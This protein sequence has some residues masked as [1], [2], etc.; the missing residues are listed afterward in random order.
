MFAYPTL[1]V[2]AALGFNF[3]IN[4]AKNKKM[5]IAFTVLPVVLLFDPFIFTVRN[6]PYEATYCN[7]F[8]GGVKGAYGN[9]DLY[10]LDG[11][12]R[13]AAEWI[14]ADVAKNGAPD[15]T[16]KTLVATWHQSDYYFRKDTA[17]FSINYVRWEERNSVD[18]D[19][20]FYAIAGV[21]HLRRSKEAYPPQNT[22]YQVK[23]DG[24]PIALVLKREDR[25]SYYGDIAFLQ[26]DYAKA[27]TQLLKALEYDAYDEQ[28]LNDFIQIYLAAGKPEDIDIAMELAEHWQ[29]FAKNDLNA[30]TFMGRLYF[31]K[32][33]FAN[34]LLMANTLIELHPH[35]INGLLIAAYVYER[36]NNLE[37]AWH[38]LSNIVMKQDCKPAYELMLHI[39]NRIGDE[40]AAQQISE[41]LKNLE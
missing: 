39:V 34:A 32:G 21:H 3:L 36:Q 24:V 16:R 8:V 9:Y 35:Q 11:S 10:D 37:E 17:N 38:T 6:H 33:D 40:D 29:S 2:A 28:A 15:P 41:K 12:K 20:A 5:K 1:V 13:E 4:W 27:Q 31:Y 19:Y 14:L 22:V 26:G 25:S 23:V 30:L 7:R 18:W